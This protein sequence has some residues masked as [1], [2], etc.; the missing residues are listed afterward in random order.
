MIRTN[1]LSFARKTES[2]N[3]A[4]LL[5]MIIIYVRGHS[6]FGIRPSRRMIPGRYDLYLYNPH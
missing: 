4:K 5:D 1:R 6:S 3:N 2:P